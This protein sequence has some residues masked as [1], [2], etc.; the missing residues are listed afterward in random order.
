[1]DSNT[2][3]DLSSRTVAEPWHGDMVNPFFLAAILG[4]RL[5]INKK[6]DAIKKALFYGKDTKG[7]V[8]LNLNGDKHEL[9]DD[10]LT[11]HAA[12]G[13]DTEAAEIVELVVNGR[14]T[15]EKVLDEGGDMLWYLALLFRRHGITFDEAMDRN[16]A[17]LE[18][19]F[20]NG[21]TS[22]AALNRNEAIE[23]AVFQ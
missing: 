13:I 5:A 23:S 17:K 12:L 19:R 7:L 16:I 22:R 20:P 1:M 9:A 10:T 11:L 2:Y 6:V 8:P 15:R 18:A 14:V 3:L 21:F 4:D